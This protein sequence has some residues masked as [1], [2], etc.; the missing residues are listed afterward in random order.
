MV[1]LTDFELLAYLDGALSQPEREALEARLAV[2]PELKARLRELASGGRPFAE[3]YDF[4]L[5][6]APRERLLASLER[7]QAAFGEKQATQRPFSVRQWLRPLAAAVVIFL[8]GG[9]AG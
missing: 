6:S 3:A 4:L 8:A 1:D 9:A 2:A 7:A 5:R